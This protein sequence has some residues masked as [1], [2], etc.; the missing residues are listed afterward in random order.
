[1]ILAILLDEMERRTGKPI[2][3]LF[4]LV[5]TMS[6]GGILALGLVAPGENN[7]SRYRARDL[8][9]IYEERGRDVFKKSGWRHIPL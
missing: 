4:D 9:K 6:T 8:L 1:M 5:A 2:S 3:D 7:K